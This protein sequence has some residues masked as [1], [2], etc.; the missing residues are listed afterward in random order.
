MDFYRSKSKE[1][2]EADETSSRDSAGTGT[3]PSSLRDVRIA[4]RFDA[5]ENEAAAMLVTLSRST[6]PSF[7]PPSSHKSSCG[8]PRVLQSPLTVGSKHNLF[9]PIAGVPSTSPVQ[10]T[11]SQAWHSVRTTNGETVV[12]QHISGGSVIGQDNKSKIQSVI[13]P[14]ILRPRISQGPVSVIQMP[15][16][17][18]IQSN[19]AILSQSHSDTR[20]TSSVSTIGG[21]VISNPNFPNRNDGTEKNLNSVIKDLRTENQQTF[22]AVSKDGQSSNGTTSTIITT[23]TPINLI[24]TGPM[25]LTPLIVQTS[26]NGKPQVQMSTRYQPFSVI[27]ITKQIQ[28]TAGTQPSVV[29]APTSIVS[30]SPDRQ[31]QLFATSTANSVLTNSGTSRVLVTGNPLG[32]RTTIL[33]TSAGA[34]SSAQS[35]NSTTTTPSRVSI[36][37]QNGSN[38]I[39]FNGLS[40]VSA[41]SSPPQLIIPE[42][43]TGNSIEPSVVLVRPGTKVEGVSANIMVVETTRTSAVT[44]ANTTQNTIS[45]SS[46]ITPATPTQLLPVVPALPP[47]RTQNENE[48]NNSAKVFP[49]QSLL[50]FLTPTPSPPQHCAQQNGTPDSPLSGAAPKEHP[51]QE[52]DLGL[53]DISEEG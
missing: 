40:M 26:G 47:E 11:N 24:K 45:T 51:G 36:V 49:W 48:D 41:P 46:V 35:P 18:S 14:E 17:A 39:S 10:S 13:R 34:I 5:D 31:R 44:I 3:S 52:I 22:L 25:T 37:S 32:V 43:S 6:S 4:G 2:S 33:T 15:P 27:P 23:S 29:L 12:V 42:N 9:M 8:S 20:T 16:V 30:W 1:T 21:I 7:S 38:G 50:P 28:V 53:P 19:S